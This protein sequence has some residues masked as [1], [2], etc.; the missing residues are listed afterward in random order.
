MRRK[1]MKG[2]RAY[3]IGGPEVLR[4]EEIPSLKPGPGEALV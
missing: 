1:G 3:E 4:Y 2:I